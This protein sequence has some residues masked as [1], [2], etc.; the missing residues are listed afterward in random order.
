MTDTAQAAEAATSQK[1]ALEIEKLRLELVYIRRNFW[2]QA[3][4]SVLLISVALVVFYFFQRPQIEQMEATRVATEKLHIVTAI[5]NA[6]GL[7][8]ERDKK[9]AFDLMA[10]VWPQYSFITSIG[11]SETVIASIT[12]TQQGAPT[13]TVPPPPLP[14]LPAFPRP[15]P[16]L[17]KR[18]TEALCVDSRSK[19]DDLTRV[20]IRLQNDIAS[21]DAG[22][23]SGRP[24]GKG[25]VWAA[26]TRQQA[27]VRAE[28]ELL[29]RRVRDC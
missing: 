21:E 2:V 13:P 14:Q 8:N 25:P 19:L 24:A 1:D 26:L 3:I 7:D 16:S 9:K 22:G 18:I 17:E 20:S 12:P 28:M 10:T 15:S 5:I 4:N 6:Q 29:Q 23:A 27:K 11:E